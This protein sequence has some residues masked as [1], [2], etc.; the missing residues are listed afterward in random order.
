MRHLY[1][2]RHGLS[3]TN[4]LGVYSGQTET[5]LSETG[6]EQSRQAGEILKKLG[7]DTIA[8]SPLSRA[9]ETAEIIADVLSY[10]K[11][12]IY[13]SKLLTERELGVLEG[14]PYEVGLADDDK[15]KGIELSV[16]LFARAKNA[17]QWLDSLDGETILVVSHGAVGRAIRHSIPGGYK[18]EDP[19]KF[20]NGEVVKLI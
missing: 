7:I 3:V 18:F 4:E 12:K 6:R 20:K 11:D 10:P 14:Q 17:L 16:D 5:P 19:R 1:F 13:V 8:S 9:L 15:I 2:I